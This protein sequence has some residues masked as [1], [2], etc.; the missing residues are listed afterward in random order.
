MFTGTT[1]GDPL[2]GVM[3]ALALLAALD[4][5]RRTGEG[6]HIDLSQAE[7]TAMFTGDL[8]AHVSAGGEEP[9]RQG[10]FNPLM[11][12]DGMYRCR[13]KDR[14]VA[15]A[16]RDDRDWSELAGLLG[17]EADA[18][19]GSLETRLDGREELD[20]ALSAWTAKRSA[21]EAM[22][23]LQER[24]VPAGVV[25]NGRDLFKNEH[26][27]ERGFFLP[28]ERAEVG[29]KHYP[30]Q[31]FRLSGLPLAAERPAPLLGQHNAEVLGGLLGLSADELADLEAA[32]VIG[33]L[34]L[35]AKA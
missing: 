13:G 19:F 3:G 22:H 7:A 29:A 10:N 27:R 23:L 28:L 24:G 2:A 1:G 8:L 34:P 32:D 11:A 18:R 6:Q 20:A 25:M 30:S 12:P 26:L 21:E 35:A 16:C 33:T 15:I 31:P 17:L 14:W 4:H 9:G 5:R